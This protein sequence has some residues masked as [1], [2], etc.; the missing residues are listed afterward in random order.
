MSWHSHPERIV[1][2]GLSVWEDWAVTQLHTP[3]GTQHAGAEGVMEPAG[4]GTT[5]INFYG[6]SMNLCLFYTG[7]KKM[8]HP[9][10]APCLYVLCEWGQAPIC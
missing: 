9:T 5:D 6:A 1:E 4:I 10:P 8:T 2:A 7:V 3:C